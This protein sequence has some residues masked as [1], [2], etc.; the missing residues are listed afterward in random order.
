MTGETEALEA[1]LDA[2]EAGIVQARNIL[3]GSSETWNPD[4]I[5][6]ESTNGAKGIYEKSQDV[7]SPDFKA[8]V[9]DLAVHNNKLAR[10]GMFYWLFQNGATVGRKK[11]KYQKKIT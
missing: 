7:N 10:K 5:K 6:W 11:A 1:L 9:K 8:L 2:F 3:K 4:K